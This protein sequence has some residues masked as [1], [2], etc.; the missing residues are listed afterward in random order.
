MSRPGRPNV[1]KE[2]KG[3]ER[4]RRKGKERTKERE[5]E[6]T[7]EKEIGKWERMRSVGKKEKKLKKA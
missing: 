4:E 5:R 3:R 6:R 2:G 7:R 1:Q